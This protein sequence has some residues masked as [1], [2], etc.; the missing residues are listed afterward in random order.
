MVSQYSFAQDHTNK[1]FIMTIL[2]LVCS[3]VHSSKVK[4]NVQYRTRYCSIFLSSFFFFLASY[5]ERNAHKGPMDRIP[6]GLASNKQTVSRV[7]EGSWSQRGIIHTV[8]YVQTVK[9]VMS[10][11][12]HHPGIME[13]GKSFWS[14]KL[15]GIRIFLA[16]PLLIRKELYSI[17]GQEVFNP[18]HP[19]IPCW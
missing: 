9:N 18:W 19:R 12:R 6:N 10:Y 1:P 3:N 8:L 4:R 14:G 2:S 15:L 17:P 16:L 13:T 7:P 11:L 5:M